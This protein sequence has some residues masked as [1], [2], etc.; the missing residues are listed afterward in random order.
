M[1][2]SFRT[3]ARV[4]VFLALA[5]CLGMDPG[6][7][8][9]P[10]PAA[11]AAPGA[12]VPVRVVAGKLVVT[13]DVST[14]VR[15]LPVNLFLEFENP[16][17]L[18]L[19]NRAAGAM[20]TEAR[21][22]STIPITIHFPDLDIRVEKREHGPE[23]TYEDF[24]KYH[25]EDLGE[26]AVVGTIGHGIL[27]KYHLVFD[28]KDGVLEISAPRARDPEPPEEK[29]DVSVVDVLAPERDSSGAL[30]VS[31]TASRP[32]WRSGPR[33]STRSSTSVLARRKKRPAGDVGA[34]RV[35]AF[36][37]SQ[38]VA[39]RPEEVVQVHPDGA[40]GVAGINLLQHFRVAI[41]R[42]NRRVTF[43][44][45][46]SPDFPVADLAYFKA[47]V[48]EEGDAVEA[49]PRGPPRRPPGP[50]GRAAAHRPALG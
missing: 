49:F 13:C 27:S 32:H 48:E 3:L 33:S 14:R 45:T 7:A 41:D 15:R 30:S 2:L 29:A 37:A 26:V 8:D 40:F 46:Q 17:G 20:R 16:C 22:G 28:L 21:D 50:R 18:Q 10:Q 24:T 11:D 23:K 38:Y 35:G 39:W 34:V 47:R 9:D 31:R 19:H 36:D 4:A 44:E 6:F 5:L 42:V 12:R 43:E 25:G 1:A